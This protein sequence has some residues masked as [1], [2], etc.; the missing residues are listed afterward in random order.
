[1]E[2]AQLTRRANWERIKKNEDGGKK[3]SDI[4]GGWLEDIYIHM[5]TTETRGTTSNVMP[6]AKAERS[7]V[8]GRELF[9]WDVRHG[10]AWGT[11]KDGLR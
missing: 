2:K 4:L 10:M 5:E 8:W 11:R 7:F 1:M 6:A 3:K 9:G